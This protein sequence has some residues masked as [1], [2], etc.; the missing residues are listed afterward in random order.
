V[1]TQSALPALQKLMNR[2]PTF[3]PLCYRTGKTGG[4]LVICVRVLEHFHAHRQT[5][6]SA[7]EVGGQLF[8]EF[9]PGRIC[10]CLATG[11]ASADKRSRFW[12]VPDQKRQNAEIQKHFKERLHFVGDWHTHPEPTPTP[13]GTDLNSM[14]DC[15]KQSRHQLKSFVMIIV[16]QAEFP[17]GLWV[18]LHTEKR[19]DRLKLISGNSLTCCNGQNPDQL[20]A[21]FSNDLQKEIDR[22]R[23]VAGGHQ[24]T[25]CE[26]KSIRHER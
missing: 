10:I 1:G 15:F 18:S 5:Q 2:K 25:G 8:A 4:E 6:A 16:G 24:Q 21:Q 3:E 23:V 13:S 11:Q 14:R 12:F 17:D 9:Q 19:T 7:S 26:R 22:S 20:N